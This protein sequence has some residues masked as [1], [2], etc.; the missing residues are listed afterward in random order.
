MSKQGGEK[1]PNI[2]LITT[3]QLRKD[4]VS[5]YDDSVGGYGEITPNIDH[6]AEEGVKF[7]NCNAVTPVCAP[8]RASMMTGRYPHVHGQL[9]N[10]FS[11]KSEETYWWEILQ[12]DGY[13][14]AGI[15]KMHV[16]PWDDPLNWEYN[17]RIEGKDFSGE[18]EYAKFLRNR[19]HKFNRPRFSK[20]L[21]G[22]PMWSS[23]FIDALPA[24]DQLDKY[25]ADRAIQYFDEINQS[26]EP[27]ASWVSFC[28]PHHPL[29]PPQ[30]YYNKFENFPVPEHVY[31]ASEEETKPKEQ[32]VHRAWL[33]ATEEDRK[34]AWRSYL[35]CTNFVDHQ[36]GKLIKKLDQ[37]GLLD[38]TLVIFTSDHGEML[39][40]HGL[41]DKA[42]FFYEQTIN[43]PLVVR[44]PD[45]R[46]AERSKATC[47]NFDVAPTIL[48]YAGSK[49]PG[50][51]QANS[52]NP[53]LE[54]EQE[55][56]RD[57]AVSSHLYMRM[58]KTDSAKLVYYQ[59]RPYGELYDLNNDP[60]ELENHWD[61][62]SYAELK[63]N[64]MDK[65][66]DWSIDS[67]EP[68]FTQLEEP[69]NK[70]AYKWAFEKNN[71]E[72]ILDRYFS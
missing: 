68:G 44:T 13:H 27:F 37:E 64:L 72:E 12:E 48:D 42:F 38:N 2:L 31:D 15:G 41:F 24:E 29:D 51:F 63:M 54:G 69:T 21:K 70:G 36:V 45:G 53:V 59:G 33:E 50:D 67:I 10:G 9:S 60:E 19:G 65:L 47:E 14:T 28:N 25:V 43:V 11:M 32:E 26:K 57:Y 71:E 46:E 16:E 62:P 30:A 35:A 23:T 8:T 22:E 49:I 52:L 40:D 20:E 39:F 56:L 61:D 5:A 3:D 4:V 1:E 6:L 55:E 7:E 34:I 58:V 17:R 66:L 18:D